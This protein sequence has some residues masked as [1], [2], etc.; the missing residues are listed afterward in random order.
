MSA[1]SQSSLLTHAAGNATGDTTPRATIDRLGRLP[2]EMKVAILA[3]IPDLQTLRTVTLTIPGYYTAY[4]TRQR[5]VLFHVLSNGLSP[6]MLGEACSLHAAGLIKRD[7]A[8]WET[9]V[10]KLII[11]YEVDRTLGVSLGNQ[12]VEVLR[13]MALLHL[14]IEDITSKHAAWGILNH[15]NI[16]EN[17]YTT[18]LPLSPSELNRFHRAFYH[19]EMRCAVFGRTP[20]SPVKGTFDLRSMYFAQLGALVESFY[21]WE[22]EE[23]A[24]VRHY[25]S[26]FYQGT[27]RRHASGLGVQLGESLYPACERVITA[28]P[29]PR[30]LFQYGKYT[31]SYK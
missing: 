14:T 29:F 2:I 18:P 4:K 27:L 9:V 31:C 20:L 3:S 17:P 21:D 1:S 13:E 11:A 26:T 5:H 8:D 15:P 19:Y 16:N 12:T 30:Y 6:E 10:G 7:Q 25:I 28:T 22:I 23:S 24:C